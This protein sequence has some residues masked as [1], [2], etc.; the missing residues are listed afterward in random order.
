[1]PS[2][3]LV[4]TYW[5]YKES[6]IKN[7]TLPYLQLIH[8]LDPSIEMHLF[9]LNKSHQQI[10]AEELPNIQKE[11]ALINTKLVA[12]NYNRFSLKAIMGLIGS[13]ISLIRL[14]RK[15]KITHIH[16]FCTPAGAIG[17]LSNEIHPS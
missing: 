13:I 8:S 11:L 3:I 7:F 2:R 1:M 6:L 9:T 4:L 15:Q 16:A 10:R 14:I 17:Y 12:H 5:G